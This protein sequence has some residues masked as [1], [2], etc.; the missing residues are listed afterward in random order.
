MV[1]LA[2]N[3]ALGVAVMSY[4]G[5]VAFGLNADYDALPDVGVLAAGLREAIEALLHAAGVARSRRRRGAR[6]RA[7]PAESPHLRVVET[8]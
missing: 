5:H 2:E 6:R 7:A 8:E 1:P 4:N 3:T